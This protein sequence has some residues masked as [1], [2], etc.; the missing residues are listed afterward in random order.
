M[1]DTVLMVSDFSPNTMLAQLERRGF[2]VSAGAFGAVEPT[3][4]TG[5][6]DWLLVWTTPE[7]V[8]PSFGRLL[9]YEDVDQTFL[10]AEVD[11]F[12]ARVHAAPRDKGVL[13]ASWTIPAVRRG[14][15]LIE[16]DAARGA[17]GA[18]M[19]MNLR[20]AE[21]LAEKPG[22]YL[23]DAQ[24]WMALAGGK[25]WQPKL[26]FLNKTPYDV[27]VFQSAADDVSAAIRGLTGQAR[28]LLVLDLDNTLWSGIVGEEGWE[29]LRI[30]G[31]D[32]I[33]EAMADFQ[34]R[35]RSLTRRGVILAIASKNDEAVA[36][37]AIRKHPEMVLTLDDFA[38]WRINW[39]DK[40]ANIVSLVEELGLGLQS[41]AFIDDQQ[42]E[43][44]RV[45]E[46]L[47]EVLVPDWPDDKLVYGRALE[48][49]D[50]FDAPA[51]TD[52]DRA[53]GGM[54]V[55]ERHRQEHRTAVASHDDW[56]A[57]LGT[58]VRVESLSP[59]N[60]P[61]IAQLLNKTNQLNLATRRMTEAEIKRWASEKGNTVLAFRVSDRFGDA[62]L[63]GIIG[64]S[65]MREEAE[66]TDFLLSCRVMGR[67]VEETML[68]TAVDV[69]NRQGARVLRA[70]Y[71]PTPK[72]RPCL[73]FFQNASGFYPDGTCFFW[74][75]GVYAVPDCVTVVHP[76]Q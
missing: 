57:G 9:R 15:G 18:L 43:R 55:A 45:R 30:G 7:R 46:A 25:A 70:H 6:A 26:W 44:E 56:L 53:R 42:R 69:A 11:E 12:A 39:A 48:A 24:R 16:L 49:L 2:V 27:K 61:R 14:L 51:L 75:D 8:C 4:A 58:T 65:I 63:C 33:G 13:V 41:V 62:G 1:S 52:E 32:P 34:R 35:V 20:L 64:V 66:L 59:G 23:L 67:C 68:A 38:A 72:N 22:A 28:K 29:N 17:S 50:C 21:K 60:L 37:E 76:E 74:E 3:L 31:H 10:D 71:Q 54:Y 5:G 19:R 36:L 47:P 73:E 40:A